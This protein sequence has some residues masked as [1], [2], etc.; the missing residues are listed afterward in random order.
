M[1]IRIKYEK[2]LKEVFEKLTFMCRQ[3]EIAI[4]KSIKALSDK[5]KELAKEVIEGDKDIDNSEREIEHCCLKILLMEHPVAS[6]FREVSAA[7]KMITDLERIGDQASDICEIT[8]QFGEEA[9]IKRVYHIPQMAEIAIDMVKQGV[10]SYINRDLEQARSLDEKD[11]E[12]DKLFEIIKNDLINLIKKDENN[13]NQAIL[14]I[15]IAKYLE[16]ISDHAVNLGEWVE[17]AITGK[18]S[19]Y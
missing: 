5:D 4:E 15:M 16:R 2:E 17:Y 1:S 14:F 3:I 11:D 12:V 13:A 8:L 18:H 9:Y 6:D 10:E 19:K 7:L